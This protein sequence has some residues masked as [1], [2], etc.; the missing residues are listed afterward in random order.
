MFE[1]LSMRRLLRK[2]QE[3]GE[4]KVREKVIWCAVSQSCFTEKQKE[5]DSA[6]SNI[7]RVLKLTLHE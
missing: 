6:F 4:I 3:S 1:V 7:T 5:T 2:F